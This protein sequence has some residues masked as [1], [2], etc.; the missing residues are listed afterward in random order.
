MMQKTMLVVAIL[1]LA[2]SA[3]ATAPE[4]PRTVAQASS[5]PPDAP[6][7]PSSPPG[8]TQPSPSVDPRVQ[9]SIQRYNAG[10]AALQRRDLEYAVYQ[11][12][13]AIRL[14]P[15]LTEAHHNLGIALLQLRQPLQAIDAF[16]RAL[17]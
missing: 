9:E 2:G 12:R 13:Q 10:V 1:S 11:F 15:D 7:S 6:L 5:T 16:N 17:E 14:N 4:V 3:F 8:A